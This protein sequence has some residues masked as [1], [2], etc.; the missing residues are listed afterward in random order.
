[1][2]PRLPGGSARVPVVSLAA[3]EAAIVAR[4]GALPADPAMRAAAII[5]AEKA[6][7]VREG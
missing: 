3:L 7:G 5:A 2:T 1:M 4:L 6:A